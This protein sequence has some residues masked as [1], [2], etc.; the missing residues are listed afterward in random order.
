MEKE[1]GGGKRKGKRRNGKRRRKEEGWRAEKLIELRRNR[2]RIRSPK[3][4]SFMKEVFDLNYYP[5]SI[6]ELLVLD[7]HF[8][9]SIQ[10]ITGV[11]FSLP[12][13][14]SR[15]YWCWILIVFAKLIYF[16]KIC[17][18][19]VDVVPLGKECF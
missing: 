3:I 12:T 18:K 9:L 5:L 17:E 13:F 6:Q 2:K 19:L 16:V 11:G 8:P 1:R 15:D 7:F 10:E 4:L 14:Y